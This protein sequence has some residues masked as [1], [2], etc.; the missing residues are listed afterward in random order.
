MENPLVEEYLRARAARDEAQARLDELSARL[1]KQM[2]ADQRK[3]FRWKNRGRSFSLTYV[4]KHTTM[5]DERGL[6]KALTAKVFDRYTK[7]MLDRKAMEEAM[8][9]GQVDPVTVSRYVT[10]KPQ[11]TYLEYRDK[12][13]P[14]SEETPDGEAAD[15]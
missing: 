8:S 15:R 14:T 5:I 13:D 10:L 12:E 9:T 4:Q 3:S 7:R 6:R 11:R 1:I 2:E